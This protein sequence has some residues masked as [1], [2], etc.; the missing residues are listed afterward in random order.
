MRSKSGEQWQA[1]GK[2]KEVNGSEKREKNKV[3]CIFRV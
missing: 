2:E 3:K 1:G